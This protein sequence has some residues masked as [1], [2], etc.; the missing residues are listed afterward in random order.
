MSSPRQSVSDSDEG[1]PAQNTSS[2]V[3]YSTVVPNGYRDQ[4]PPVQVFS[5]SESTQPLL[6]SEERPE[7]QQ[8]LG[9]D[10]STPKHNY[11]KQ[12]GNWDETVTDG[13]HL[14]RVKQISPIS[15]EDS[16][17]LH[18]TQMCGSGGSGPEGGEHGV[19]LPGVFHPSPEGA[20][21]QFEPVKI[22]TVTDDGMP[23]CYL[24]QTV[25]QGGYMPQ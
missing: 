21:M 6:D 4:T 24:P 9:S 16:A 23:K 5:R 8:V 15:E 7:D 20:P 18:G 17:G 13:S 14:E 3:Q 22:N 1:E 19:V 11:F 25:R 2:T 10:N 12:N